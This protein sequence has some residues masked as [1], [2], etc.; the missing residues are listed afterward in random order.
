MTVIPLVS[1]RKHFY[2]AGLI[3]N[4][5]DVRLADISDP[6]P[7]GSTG[8]TWETLSEMVRGRHVVLMVHG[9]NSSFR[10]VCDAYSR[11]IGF[12]REFSLAGEVFAGYLWP[13]GDK[14]FHY[15]S[16]RRRSAAVS[17]RL[18]VLLGMLEEEA[19]RV[20][21]VAHSLGCLVVFEAMRRLGS[22]GFGYLHMMAAAVRNHMLSGGE[23]FSRAVSASRGTVVFKSRNDMVLSHGFPIGES[24]SEALGFS[25]PVPEKT[26]SINTLTVDCTGLSAPMR[27]NGYSRRPEPYRFIAG[28]PERI[29]AP[30]TV[31]VE[32]LPDARVPRLQRIWAVDLQA[33]QK[34]ELS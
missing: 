34:G 31:Y 23:G 24:G 4:R 18:S 21:V 29:T 30:S 26:V 10:K 7:G 17:K 19:S 33:E 14:F 6:R 8:T 5:D 25:G 3:S 16:V 22:P 2:K 9:Y 12:H 32:E 13:G 28:L 27:H 11:I 1:S 15:W 20:D